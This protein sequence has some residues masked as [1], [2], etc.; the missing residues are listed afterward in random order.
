MV[1]W[2]LLTRLS[3]LWLLNPRYKSENKQRN[4]WTESMQLKTKQNKTKNNNWTNK[5]NYTKELRIWLLAPK[6]GMAWKS[7]YLLQ[8]N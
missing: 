6:Y 4:H 1:N 2:L 8:L 7:F 3:L 5:L